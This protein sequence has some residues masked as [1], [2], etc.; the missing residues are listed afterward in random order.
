MKQ[1]IYT[2]GEVFI[3][4]LICGYM[5][6]LGGCA[7]TPTETIVNEH[8]NHVNDVLDYSYNNIDQTSDV[9]FLEEELKNCRTGLLSTEQSYKAE[10]ATCNAQTNYWRLSSAGLFVLLCV[11]IF[12]FAKKRII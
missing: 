10:I 3:A 4:C 8:V 5:L 7:K 2:I 6:L 1:T 11:A 9:V 12:L